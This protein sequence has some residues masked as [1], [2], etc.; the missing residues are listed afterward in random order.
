MILFLH[1]RLFLLFFFVKK[2]VLVTSDVIISTAYTI[3]ANTLNYKFI[4]SKIIAKIN[5]Y[6]GK[7][8]QN[9]SCPSRMIRRLDMIYV[10]IKT[11]NYQVISNSMG[12][13]T[14][15]RFRHQGR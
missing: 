1:A 9:K 13:M 14:C 4:Y 5:V 6:W 12:V 2:H 8:Q 7:N 15:T 10:L 11:K 3:F